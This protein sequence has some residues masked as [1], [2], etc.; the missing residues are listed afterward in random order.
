MCPLTFHALIAPTIDEFFNTPVS[1]NDVPSDLPPMVAEAMELA[2]PV[3]PKLPKPKAKRR[4]A[5]SEQG[6]ASLQAHANQNRPW[7]HATGPRTP[8]G[9][10]ASRRNASKNRYLKVEHR[11]FRQSIRSLGALFEIWWGKPGSKRWNAARGNV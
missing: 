4:Y 5:L 2:F 3:V 1:L 11:A 8:Q 10:N 6:R 9:K 7:Q